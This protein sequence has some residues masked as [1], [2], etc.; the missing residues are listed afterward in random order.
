MP[1]FSHITIAGHLGKD[2]ECKAVAE[3]Y[4]LNFSVAVTR[5]T[6]DSEI[7]T[8]WRCAYWCKKNTLAQYL[9]KGTAILVSGEAYQRPYEKDGQQRLSLEIEAQ[10]VQLLGG[11]PA[12]GEPTAEEAK[13]SQK[14]ALA[15]DVNDEEPPF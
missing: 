10:S 8:W 15:R 6:K 11:K 1:N 5:K 3:R 2:C 12:A 4:V 9:K 14:Q 7:T 13:P